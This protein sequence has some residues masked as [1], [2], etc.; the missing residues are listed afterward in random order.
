MKIQSTY[1]LF[2][3]LALGCVCASCGSLG[4]IFGGQDNLPVSGVT[5]WAKIDRFAEFELIQ[6]FALTSDDKTE[7]LEPSLLRTEG[8]YRM[9]FE[10]A[11]FDEGT[12][13][14][15][16][17]QSAVYLAESPD[18]LDWKVV[19]DEQPVLE[20]DRTW[21]DGYVGAP[22][23]IRVDD[24]YV[25]YFGGGR[26]AG[27]GRADSPDGIVWTKHEANPVLVPDQDWEGGTLG[28]VLSPG[29]VFYEG[30]VHLWYAGGV[31]GY[32]LLDQLQG[33]A[34]GYARSDDGVVFEKT[35]A[36]L[37][38][39][40]SH[41][42]RVRPVLEPAKDWEGRLSEGDGSGA[43][44]MPGVLLDTRAEQVVFRLYYSGNRIGGMYEDNVSIGYAGS[45]DGLEFVRADDLLNPVVTETFALTVDGVSDLLDYDEFSASVIR[46]RADR[47]LMAFAQ[48][49]ALNWLSYGLKGIGLASCPPRPE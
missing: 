9:Y 14:L 21:E 7:F 41:A 38:T 20:A 15:A 42:G 23:V 26:G 2:L 46:D 25:M 43:V 17:T 37:R 40:T 6:P 44:G 5:P 34:I 28:R 27:I 4:D 12:G 11:R 32:G 10:V 1:A 35:D 22:C 29:A 3:V 49:D 16:H 13:G 47:Y 36:D 39:A 8:L 24:G 30:I 48:I 33:R 31:S 18:G 45:F 19:N